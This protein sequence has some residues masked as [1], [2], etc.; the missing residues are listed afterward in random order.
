[1]AD[2]TLGF[3]VEHPTRK[4]GNSFTHTLLQFAKDADMDEHVV[5][6]RPGLG[7]TI[8][9]LGPGEMEMTAAVRVSAATFAA[10]FTALV[11]LKNFKGTVGT[12]TVTPGLTG[13]RQ[14][15]AAETHKKV[16]I[17]NVTP[18]DGTPTAGQTENAVRVLLTMRKLRLV[19]GVTG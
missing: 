3:V 11:A 13:H 19:G 2:D 10:F 15:R 16:Y 9:Y 7:T 18:V 5:K 17:E 12:L 8:C 6:R 14:E 4:E 1:M